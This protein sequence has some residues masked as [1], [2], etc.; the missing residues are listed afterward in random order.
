MNEQ[1]NISHMRS[2]LPL[3]GHQKLLSQVILKNI[4][5]DIREP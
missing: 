4:C 5:M 2:L 1:E 3:T